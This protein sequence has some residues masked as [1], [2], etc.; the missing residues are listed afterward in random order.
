[1]A[2]RTCRPGVVA[3]TTL[4][5]A[6]LGCAG[7][8]AG[9][10]AGRASST[11]T[12]QAAIGGSPRPG[13]VIDG[14]TFARRVSA[15]TTA[16]RSVRIR[17]T[18]PGQGTVSVLDQK[19]VSSRRTDTA[20][21][22]DTLPLRLIGDRYYNADPSAPE[23][24]ISRSTRTTGPDRN[25]VRAMRA[26]EPRARAAV[27]REGSTTYVG[28]LGRGRAALRHY[29]TKTPPARALAFFVPTLSTLDVEG[30]AAHRPVTYDTWLD[31]RNRPARMV[32]TIPDVDREDRP[33]I[34]TTR[35]QRWGLPVKIAPPPAARTT[36]LEQ[37]APTGT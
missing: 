20:G 13:S 3:S 37:A 11:G 4:V 7:C 30:K 21:T 9:P 14:T 32:I 18:M 36:V 31:A 29:R 34:M 19:W 25:I 16:A 33:M 12:A 2:H 28:T 24:W 23:N 26:A 17:T 5:L 27:Y 6:L 22:S 10:E 1:M 8:G 15:A 35:F